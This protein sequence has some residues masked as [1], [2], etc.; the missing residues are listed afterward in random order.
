MSTIGAKLC[1]HRAAAKLT[2]QEIAERLGIKPN[3]YGSWEAGHTYPSGRYFPELAAIFGVSIEQLFPDKN[4]SVPNK[5]NTTAQKMDEIKAMKLVL[6]SKEEVIA[7]K[8]AII[9]AQSA[10]IEKLQQELK[11]CQTSQGK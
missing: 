6:Q 9:A 2:Q 7:A 4:G 3:T 1:Q 5:I 10:Q 8:D 11:K